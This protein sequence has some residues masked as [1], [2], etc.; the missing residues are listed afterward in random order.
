MKLKAARSQQSEKRP[1]MTDVIDDE[2]LL[3]L[4]QLDEYVV[5]PDPHT[6]LNGL[7]LEDDKRA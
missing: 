5:D 2:A 1:A 7:K 4:V 3:G 6:H